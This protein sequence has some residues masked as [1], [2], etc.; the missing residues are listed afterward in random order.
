MS[1]PSAWALE[2]AQEV[3]GGMANDWSD[4]V[5]LTA[6]ALDSAVAEHVVVIAAK[7]TALWEAAACTHQ[8]LGG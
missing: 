3:V 6:L 5:R 7:N 2:R 4:S 8:S 1:D